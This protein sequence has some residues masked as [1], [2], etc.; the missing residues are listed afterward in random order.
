MVDV[1]LRGNS[2]VAYTRTDFNCIVTAQASVGG[3]SGHV[4]GEFKI[5]ANCGLAR[6]CKPLR[7]GCQSGLMDRS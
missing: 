2:L 4:A 1:C 6:F 7:E 3:L 5:V